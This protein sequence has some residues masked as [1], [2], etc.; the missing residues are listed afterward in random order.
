MPTEES[1]IP[2]GGNR[3]PITAYA[4]I[5]QSYWS[6]A[7]RQYTTES[8][9]ISR[10]FFWDNSDGTGTESII[11]TYDNTPMRKHIKRSPRHLGTCVLRPGHRHPTKLTGSYFTDRYTQG[12]MELKLISR[13]VDVGSYVEATD[14]AQKAA[15]QPK[16]RSWIPWPRS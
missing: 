16:S 8:S 11:F 7:I 2:A 13:N 1:H 3:G 5:T 10:S 6:I 14:A 9:S 15:T 4:V 12:D